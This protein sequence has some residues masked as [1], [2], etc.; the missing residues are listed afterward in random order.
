[1]RS[2]RVLTGA[3]Y[4]L[5][6]VRLARRAA[7]RSPS[8]LAHSGALPAF[9]LPSPAV[10]PQLVIAPSPSARWRGSLIRRSRC[11]TCFSAAARHAVR[12]RCKAGLR[13]D[14]VL[15]VIALAIRAAPD[16]C[17][18]QSGMKAWHTF[19]LSQQTRRPFTAALSALFSH[20]EAHLDTLRPFRLVVVFSCGIAPTHSVHVRSMQPAHDCT[21]DDRLAATWVPSVKPARS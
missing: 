9:H 11:W 15:R 18:T 13:V 19:V 10:G 3:F 16:G 7:Q 1:L 12:K 2:T 21:Q 14:R 20:Y 5:S 4:L 6:T 8:R 17:C